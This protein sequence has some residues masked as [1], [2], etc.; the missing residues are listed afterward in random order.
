MGWLG[1]T[2][3]S[4]EIERT[5]A[6]RDARRSGGGFPVTRTNPYR[7]LMSERPDIERVLAILSGFRLGIQGGEHQDRAAC[8]CA[9]RC[10]SRR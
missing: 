5:W 9:S 1:S 10:W 4:F 8:L 3:H 7:S 6:G 2:R